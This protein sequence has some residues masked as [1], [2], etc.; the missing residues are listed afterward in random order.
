MANP[1]AI[2][3]VKEVEIKMLYQS[4]ATKL[5]G[6]ESK[7]KWLFN[8]LDAERLMLEIIVKEKDA[9]EFRAAG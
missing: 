1:S 6:L 4:E 8:L 7:F 2:N 9:G 5:D 3:T